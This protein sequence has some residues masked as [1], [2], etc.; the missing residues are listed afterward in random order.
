MKNS[1]TT[2]REQRKKVVGRKLVYGVASSRPARATKVKPYDV[3]ESIKSSWS[4][5]VRQAMIK[6]YRGML[7]ILETKPF[8]KGM[9]KVKRGERLNM[10]Q[11]T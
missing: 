6:Y 7:E 10:E 11:I 1:K 8:P 4:D 9:G 3:D 5:A 2:L